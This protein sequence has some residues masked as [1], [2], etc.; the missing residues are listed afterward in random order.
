MGSRGDSDAATG[1]GVLWVH[2]AVAAQ[3]RYAMLWVHAAVATQLRYA[4]LWVHAA[5]A[6][7]LRDAAFFEATLGLG[8]NSLLQKVFDLATQTRKWDNPHR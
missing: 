4:M 6:A 2:A 7:Q 1:R 5:V 8:V 3:L